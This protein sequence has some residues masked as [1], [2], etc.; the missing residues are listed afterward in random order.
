MAGAAKSI[1]RLNQ[2]QSPNK[3]VSQLTIRA[4]M[5]GD[6]LGISRRVL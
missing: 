1:D 3:S 4:G 5:D 6:I 2:S